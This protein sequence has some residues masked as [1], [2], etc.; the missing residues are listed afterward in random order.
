MRWVPSPWMLQSR[1]M[2]GQSSRPHFLSQLVA[3][4]QVLLYPLLHLKVSLFS[5]NFMV[6]WSIDECL[7][8]LVNVLVEDEYR[9]L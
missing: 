2:Q 3:D 7:K 6:F 4:P 9:I 5:K 8:C 1:G